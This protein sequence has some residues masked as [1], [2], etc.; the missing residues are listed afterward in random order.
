MSLFTGLA[1]SFASQRPYQPGRP[2]EEVARELGLKDIDGIV[3]LA[4]NENNLGPS[5]KAMEAMN[6]DSVHAFV[7]DG[8][9][10]ICE[11]GGAGGGG[12]G[13]GWG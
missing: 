12:G 10:S 5:P 9:R 6:R 3:K 2:L 11:G 1:N 13:G 8:G 4:S 7:P